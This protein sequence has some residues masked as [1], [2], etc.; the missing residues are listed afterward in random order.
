MDP[1]REWRRL[2]LPHGFYK[3]ISYP[4]TPDTINRLYGALKSNLEDI[5]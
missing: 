3:K 5:P 1:A 2:E 4:T